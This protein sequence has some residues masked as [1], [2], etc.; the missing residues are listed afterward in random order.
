MDNCIKKIRENWIDAAKGIT[1]FLII[2]G[3]VSDGLTGWWSFAWVYGVN[4]IMFFLLSGYTLK[5]R[6]LTREYVNNRFSRLM[7]PYFVTCLFVIL[8]DIVN[9]RV[10]Y[11]DVSVAN[12]TRVTG[13]DLVRSFLASGTMQPL[14]AV[15][16]NIRIG[17]IWFLPALF[18]STVIVQ[19]VFNR[20]SDIRR[21]GIVFGLLFLTAYISKAF[22]W[23]PF[24]IQSGM[25]GAFFVWIGYWIREKRI[26]SGLKWQYYLAAQIVFFVGCI[27]GYAEAGIVRANV[28]DI[29]WSPVVG[30]CGCLLIALISRKLE[31]AKGLAYI[32]RISLTILC[33]HLFSLETLGRYYDKVLSMAHLGGNQRIWGRIIL[34]ILFDVIVSILIEQI[35]KCIPAIRIKAAELQNVLQK[36]YAG[37][38]EERGRD[39]TVDVARGIFIIAM[40]IGHFRIDG[41]LRGIIYSC[42]MVAF[43]FISGYFYKEPKSIRKTVVHMVRTYLL[44]YAVFV[45]LYFLMNYQS[46]SLRFFR[47]KILQYLMGISFAWKVFPGIP[48]VG[49]VY[50]ILL[51]FVTRLLYMLLDHAC[52]DKR[53]LTIAVLILSSAGMALGHRGY[54]LPW[55]VDISLY[56]LVFFHIGVLCRRFGI[57]EKVC[58][59]N[60]L[61]FGLSAVWAYMIFAGSMEISIRNYGNYGIVILGAVSGILVI[62]ML[63]SYIR[64]KLHVLRKILS[65]A[66]RDSLYIIIVHVLLHDM[67]IVT[68]GK[69]VDPAFLPFM[70]ISLA[71]QF[72]IAIVA[73][74]CIEVIKW[75]KVREV[76]KGE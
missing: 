28:I 29:F 41:I 53:I 35:K 4:T 60:S 16:V 56:C 64:N 5:K 37:A 33:V 51:L 1:I 24:S 22:F 32:G 76:N 74:E 11:G 42:H 45:G 25:M 17:A 58:G 48:S 2:V 6:A 57:L 50:F 23:L 62:M 55:S 10:L 68:L 18:F 19:F 43:V 13:T 14:G 20:I 73:G 72:V 8:M 46:W 61:F 52:R 12:V 63:S 27:T 36:K 3:H 15:P 69:Y 71:I 49:P 7:V 38:G 30:L 65:V 67:L 40:L 54:W 21:Q 59:I 34:E 70:I 39:I 9:C 47:E 66:G 75:K 31:N 44:P 26:L